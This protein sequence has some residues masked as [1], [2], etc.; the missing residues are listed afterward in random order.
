MKINVVGE[1]RNLSRLCV[2]SNRRAFITNVSVIHNIHRYL[3]VRSQLSYSK[4][5][6]LPE[7]MTTKHPR[8]RSSRLSALLR[9]PPEVTTTNGVVD[10]N[11]NMIA[12]LLD[13]T[14]KLLKLRSSP[15]TLI[16]FRYLWITTCKKKTTSSV[17]VRANKIFVEMRMSF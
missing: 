15:T 16:F 10:V 13:T 14:H 6:W 8:Y 11:I 2:V 17:Q 7:V 3:E 5:M 12:L 4:P 9:W 1:L